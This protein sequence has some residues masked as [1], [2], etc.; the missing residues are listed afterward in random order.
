MDFVYWLVGTFIEAHEGSWRYR[1]DLEQA[2]MV[3]LVEACIRFKPGK[4]A[5]TTFAERHIFGKV[6][7]QWHR[8][9]QL[10]P[11]ARQGTNGSGGYAPMLSCSTPLSEAVESAAQGLEDATEQEW[12]A[13]LLREAQ[14]QL[15][16]RMGPH[17]PGPERA[18][19]AFLA[20]LTLG[21]T[22]AQGASLY[23]VSRSRVG[24]IRKQAGRAFEEWARE[25]REAL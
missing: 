1:D 14:E 10:I 22:D 2:G 12:A 7:D 15:V 21:Q 24:Q 8:S 25:L 23:E 20:N 9:C 17:I 16:K 19:E 3:G 5:L 18:A 11:A 6:R 4:Y 13:Q